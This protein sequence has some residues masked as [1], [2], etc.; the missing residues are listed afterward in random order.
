MCD[1]Q[2]GVDKNG[3]DKTEFTKF[4]LCLQLLASLG[5]SLIRVV[6][7]GKNANIAHTLLQC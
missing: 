6:T 1:L 7:D 2:N 3:M 4:V 5:Q